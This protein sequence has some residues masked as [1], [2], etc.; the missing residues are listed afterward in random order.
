MKIILVL[1]LQIP[2]FASAV[3]VTIIGPCDKTPSIQKSIPMIHQK[4]SIGQLT[5]NF[6]EQNHIPYNGSEAG[7]NI[8]NNSPSGD[9]ALEVI[10]N[11]KM[12]AYG[13]CFDLNGVNL[14][15]MPDE[16][17]ITSDTDKLV[18][19]YAYSTYDSG[20]WI[21]YCVPSYTIKAKQICP[22]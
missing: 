19:Y 12:R 14:A 20:K 17:M 11:S 13:W 3:E 15:K 22:R 6:L 1:L 9:A 18:W 5:I 16:A 21:D 7:I 8:I 4:E 10:S 2:F